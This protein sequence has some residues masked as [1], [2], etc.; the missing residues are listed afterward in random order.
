MDLTS[1][2]SIIGKRIKKLRIE[3]SLI[4]KDLAKATGLH[5]TWLS[6]IETGRRAPTLKVLCRLAAVLKVEPAEFLVEEKTTAI[7][8]PKRQKLI[9]II[10]QAGPKEIKI[11]TILINAMRKA[12][13]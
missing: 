3:K 6:Q 4:Q 8:G 7:Q 11:Y 13:G 9:E 10:R 12:Q 1:I 5:W 2:R